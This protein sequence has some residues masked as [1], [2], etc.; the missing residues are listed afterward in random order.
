MARATGHN[1]GACCPA[2]DPKFP[3]LSRDHR[4]LCQ[5][6]ALVPRLGAG[7]VREAEGLT[8]GFKTICVG[9]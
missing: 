5:G 2:Q 9:V 7:W 6:A 3:V 4:R 1:C 8:V